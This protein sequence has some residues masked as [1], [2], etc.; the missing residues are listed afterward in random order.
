MP[1]ITFSE[2]IGGPVPNVE[3]EINLTGGSGLASGEQIRSIVVVAEKVAAG[4]QTADTV[5][6]TAYGSADDA[7][8]AFGTTS[9]GAIMCAAIFDYN[10]NQTG[11]GKPKAE[12]W[13]ACIDEVV[14]S[15]AAEQDFTIVGV[16]SAAGVLTLRVGGHL[17]RIAIG[18]AMAI[19]DQ[20]TAIRDVFNNAAEHKRPPLL[21]SAA[22]GVVTFTGTVKGAHLNDIALETVSQGSIG[23]STYTWEN[24]TMGGAAPGTPG[25]S[26]LAG[27][28]LTAVLAALVSFADAGQYVIPWTEDGLEGAGALVF[29]TVA[30]PAFRDHVIAKGAADVMIP[31]SLRMAWKTTPALAVTAVAALD[32]NDCE[33]VSLAVAPYSDA[34]Q[35]GTWSGE[36]AARYAAMRATQTH[37]VRSFDGLRFPDVAVS[38]PGDNFTTGELKTILEGGGSPLWRPPFKDKVE[39]SRDVAC[40]MDF[41]VL[42]T[43]AMDALDYIRNDFTAALLSQPRMSIVADDADLPLV[44][45]ITQPKVVKAFLRARAEQ[46]EAAGYMTNVASNWDN[47]TINLSGS[48]L[49]LAIPISLI[50]ALHNYMV[51]LDATVP[52]GA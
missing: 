42:D 5:S 30:P 12:V 25:L 8:A 21:A 39:M 3:I 23:T 50:P 16:S 44:E 40:R 38:A 7:I 47:V 11:S 29:D 26:A 28:D 2:A 46:L 51:R 36:I 45:W 32:T 24:T 34:G 48:T 37:V 17:F 33:R 43:M 31:T 49:Q 14:G 1:D 13:G 9:P 10:N 4:T 22:A 18:N 6:T 27:G 15:T 52:P 41:G 35:S 20:A 19:A